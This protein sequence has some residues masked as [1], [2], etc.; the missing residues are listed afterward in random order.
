MQGNGCKVWS[1]VQ[2]AAPELVGLA[3][4]VSAARSFTTVAGG[5][6]LSVLGRW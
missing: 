4:A 2:K 3:V 1:G 6:P 5:Y